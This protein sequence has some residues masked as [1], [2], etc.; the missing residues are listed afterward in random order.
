MERF[1]EFL[2]WPEKE[3]RQGRIRTEGAAEDHVPAEKVINR[4]M[5]FFRGILGCLPDVA[6]E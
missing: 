6:Q 2:S 4:R 5:D 1:T 3:R